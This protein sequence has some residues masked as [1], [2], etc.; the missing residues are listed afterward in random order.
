MTKKRCS[1][2]AENHSLFRWFLKCWM[3][4][5]TL[6][7]AHDVLSE[8]TLRFCDLG[9]F[10]ST[11][12]RRSWMDCIESRPYGTFVGACDAD[13]C[14]SRTSGMIQNP[15]VRASCLRLSGFTQR[16]YIKSH[17]RVTGSLWNLTRQEKS[18]KGIILPG[19]HF[20]SELQLN[21][22]EHK[23]RRNEISFGIAGLYGCLVTF[24][25]PF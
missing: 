12:Q 21:A 19:C 1:L 9:I 3:G 18:V 22:F 14:H 4:N 23:Q 8:W 2:G 6:Q 10:S 25:V 15:P 17:T 13:H 20:Q 11:K 24:F 5:N 7:N 16:L